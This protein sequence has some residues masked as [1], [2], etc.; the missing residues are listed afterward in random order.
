MSISRTPRKPLPVTS[1][2][3]KVN[4]NHVHLYFDRPPPTPAHVA[5]EREFLEERMRSLEE[6][7]PVGSMNIEIACGRGPTPEGLQ[8]LAKHIQEMYDIAEKA[9]LGPVTVTFGQ[10]EEEDDESEPPQDD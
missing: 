8:M 10:E 4:G 6:S 3:R 5:A 7:L 1:L 9:G 2:R